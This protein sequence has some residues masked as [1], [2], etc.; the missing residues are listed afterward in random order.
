MPSV[1]GSCLFLLLLLV[2]LQRRLFEPV[3][4]AVLFAFDAESAGPSSDCSL[5]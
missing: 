4:E 2:D 5:V 1:M 3:R